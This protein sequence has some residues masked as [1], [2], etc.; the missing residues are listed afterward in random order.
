MTKKGEVL[1][2][3]DSAKETLRHYKAFV[4]SKVDM[5]KVPFIKWEN[6]KRKNLTI[7]QLDIPKPEL[8]RIIREYDLIRQFTLKSNMD[9]FVQAITT[10]GEDAYRVTQQNIL[11]AKEL[12]RIFF[13][14]NS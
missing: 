7:E 14:K 4:D 1:I 2:R 6:G 8:K 3:R 13:N 10:G 9:R 12:P 5:K 11:L